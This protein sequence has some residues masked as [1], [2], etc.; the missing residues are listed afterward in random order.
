MAPLS[1]TLQAGRAAAVRRGLADDAFRVA[2]AA[3][4]ISSLRVDTDTH[5]DREP[6]PS[7]RVWP[8][9]QHL[10]RMRASGRFAWCREL[11]VHSWESGDAERFVDLLRSQGDLQTMLKHGATED[12]LG[13]PDLARLATRRLGT[14]R[15]SMCF[16]YRVRLGVTA[17]R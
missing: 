6:S 8:K 13:I 12:D 11:A 7:V 15:R 14:G 16:T 3:I 4:D 5:L 2:L 9:E 1:G 10:E 17:D